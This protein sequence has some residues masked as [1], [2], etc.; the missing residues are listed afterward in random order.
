MSSASRNVLLGHFVLV[1][2]QGMSLFDTRSPFIFN[3]M[4]KI[5][6]SGNVFVAETLRACYALARDYYAR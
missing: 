1:L 6:I 5:V 3:V 4:F 2:E